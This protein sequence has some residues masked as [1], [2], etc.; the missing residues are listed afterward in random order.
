MRKWIFSGT[1][2]QFYVIVFICLFF[3]KISTQL[4]RFGIV[5]ADLSAHDHGHMVGFYWSG[6]KERQE[7]Q[8]TKTAVW[9]SM[10][11]KKERPGQI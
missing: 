9:S 6:I 5:I 7:L 11:K 1:I 8:E 2:L 4:L 10:K 3:S